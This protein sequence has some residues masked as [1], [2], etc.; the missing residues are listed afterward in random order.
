[1]R[2]W[3]HLKDQVSL[4]PLSDQIVNGMQ[5]LNTADFSKSDDIIS[6]N[7]S[8]LIKLSWTEEQVN[9]RAVQMVAAI[10]SVL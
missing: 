7:I 1:M 5:D 8:C 2:K 10:K 6:R 3:N 9:E 4:F